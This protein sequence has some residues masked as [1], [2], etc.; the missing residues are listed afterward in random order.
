MSPATPPDV[1]DLRRLE[2]LEARVRELEARDSGRAKR[3]CLLVFSGELDR[4]LAAFNL[5][6]G[7]AATGSEVTMF[8]T[9][10]A[11]AALRK[12]R[13]PSDRPLLEFAFGRMLPLGAK[14]LRLSHLNLGGVGSALMRRV[15]RQ[16]NVPAFDEQLAMARELGVRITVCSTTLEMLGIRTSDLVDYP[17]LAPV[18]VAGFLQQA[19]QAG[20]TLFI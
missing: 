8:F 18:G 3:L 12:R 11:T 13:A 19:M 14:Q 6:N 1:P 20:Q 15:M 7:A 4:L 2:A 5:A 9:F 16:K 17:G 10:W